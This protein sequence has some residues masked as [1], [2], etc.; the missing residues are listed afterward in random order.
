METD[1]GERACSGS[2]A[3]SFIGRGNDVMTIVPLFPEWNTDEGQEAEPATPSS[4]RVGRSQPVRS[5]RPSRSPVEI[6]AGAAGG[7]RGR[8]VTPAEVIAQSLDRKPS[9]DRFWAVW[10][11]HQTVLRQR[12]LRLSGGNRAD[13][14]DALSAAM[15]RAAQAFD[16]QPI[17]NPGAW[18]VRI[19]HNAC[20]DQH[21]QNASRVPIKTEDDD[22]P[23]PSAAAWA[24]VEPSPEEALS[25][26][27]S[28]AAW[29]RAMRALPAS[30]VE[31]LKLHLDD[32]SDEQIAAHLNI[33]RELVRKRRQL[34]RKQLRLLL[35]I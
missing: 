29:S 7:G 23:P 20:M 24:A 26:Q 14:E 2:A 5:P 3:F 11:A 1:A 18:L 10:M 35:D 6:L 21:R 15:V 8:S 4:P 32:W 19:L 30:L 9:L 33:S 34:A 22:L 16:R 12:S 28:D 13:A 31:P 17:Q 25:Q 27:E